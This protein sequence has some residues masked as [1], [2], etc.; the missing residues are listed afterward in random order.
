MAADSE[1]RNGR[2]F[3]SFLPVFRAANLVVGNLEGAITAHDKPRKRYVPGR[4]YA[5]RFPPSFAEELKAANFQVLSIANNHSLDYGS[6]G[7]AD[8]L[9]HL[10]AAGIQSTG[11][12]GSSV[13]MRVGGLKVGIVALAHYPAFNN[14]LD[15]ETSARLVASVKAQA[16]VV[17]LTY[18]LGAEGA[19]AARLPAGPEVFLG[20]ARGDARAFARRMVEAGASA[21]VGHGP[22][23]VRAAE[24][25]NGVPVFHSTGNF[26][27][28]GGLSV[29][30]LASAAVAAEFL[31]DGKGAF[32]GA[33]AW[34]VNLWAT[35][36][37][38]VDPTGRGVHLMN[39]LSRDA[40]RDRPGFQPLILQ[41]FEGGE[42]EFRNWLRSTPV[43]G[44]AP[45]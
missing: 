20:E 40:A 39:L 18:Q 43:P 26:V 36:L 10:Q 38:V 12:P 31:F 3:E 41:G 1:S 23:V 21:L 32:R 44:I 33:R 15:L 19:S 4:S 30:G 29:A 9:R 5:F 34:P 35:K 17:L 13:V 37:P 16:D 45:P 6:V 24:C 11:Q 8:T 28:I 2:V 42:A 22:H 27:S 14:V 25:L 7:F